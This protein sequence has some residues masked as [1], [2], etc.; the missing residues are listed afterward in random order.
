VKILLVDDV[1]S[2]REMLKALLACEPGYEIVGEATDGAAG[3]RAAKDLRPDV[4]VMDLNMPVMD[5][6]EATRRIVAEVPGTDVVVFT[7]LDGPDT[8]RA[9]SEAGAAAHV[10]KGE[11]ID[12]V[13]VLE[14]LTG[15]RRTG[16][17]V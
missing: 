13:G 6:I 10:S 8:T 11:P 1:D 17:A 12:L 9:L 5:G 15:P 3:V 14:G 16:L 4:V 7:S 2:L